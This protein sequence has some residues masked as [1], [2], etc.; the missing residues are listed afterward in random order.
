MKKDVK[1]GFSHETHITC[2]HTTLMTG[3]TT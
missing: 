3:R 1:N 2:T